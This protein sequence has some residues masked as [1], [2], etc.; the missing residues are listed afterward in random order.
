MLAASGSK[1]LV[2][3]HH[4]LYYIKYI[5]LYAALKAYAWLVVDGHQRSWS[6][7][8]QFLF[9][10]MLVRI[11]YLIC[12]QMESVSRACKKKMSSILTCHFLG[13]VSLMLIP[14]LCIVL[15]RCLTTWILPIGHNWFPAEVISLDFFFV[16]SLIHVTIKP[17][18][19]FE[20]DSPSDVYYDLLISWRLLHVQD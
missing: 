14:K 19:Y 11:H 12:C 20:P 3:C 8:C 15:P 16:N 10:Y 5:W 9:L 2:A 4:F 6:I 13:K 7:T 17:I 1:E 18:S